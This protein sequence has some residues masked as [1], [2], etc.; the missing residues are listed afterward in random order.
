MK[1]IIDKAYLFSR[2]FAAIALALLLFLTVLDVFLSHA[3]LVFI[4]GVFE[5]SALLLSLMVFF[6]IACA[7]ASYGRYYVGIL[8]K[9]LPRAGKRAV[10]IICS[11]LYLG[12]ALVMTGCIVFFAIAQIRRGDHTMA[13]QIP[14]GIVS[15]LGAVGM[16]MYCLSVAGS[17]VSAIKD[18][19][20]DAE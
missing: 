9:A 10:S 17:L 5:V 6:G 2:Y 13:L 19:G 12:I 11:F 18:R 15:T 4:P 16:A 1:M 3:F 8:Y 20:G 7:H 14:L